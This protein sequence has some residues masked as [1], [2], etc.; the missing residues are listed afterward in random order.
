MASLI[1]NSKY[2]KAV[3]DAG[4]VIARANKMGPDDWLVW[5]RETNAGTRTTK[6][7]AIQT[8]LAAIQ[9]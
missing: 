8:L 5:I 3:G 1:I 2:M 6:D 4:A 9:P 7:R